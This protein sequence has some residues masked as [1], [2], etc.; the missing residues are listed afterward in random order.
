MFYFPSSSLTCENKTTRTI[1]SKLLFA[2]LDE[3]RPCSEFRI[4]E[5]DSDCIPRLWSNEY[6]FEGND[7]A[8]WKLFFLSIIPTSRSAMTDQ[9]YKLS[10]TLAGHAADV[11]ALATAPRSISSSSSN[12]SSPYSATHPVLFSSSRDGTARSWI[13]ATAGQSG[14]GGAGEGAA[15]GEKVGLKDSLSVERKDTKVSSMQWNGYPE[16]LGK[17]NQVNTNYSF[18]CCGNPL[19]HSFRLLMPFLHHLCRLLTH[20]WTRQIDPRLAVTSS[21]GSNSLDFFVSRSQSHPHWSRRQRLCTE[22]KRRWKDYR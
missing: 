17:L 9:R 3:Q 20:C 5:L 14:T 21:F 15:S 16:T 22:C 1:S 4:L 8:R 10:A 2:K 11:R 18:R 13:S 6:S 19:S 12:S 7:E